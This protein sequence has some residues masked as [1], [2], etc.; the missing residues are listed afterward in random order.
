MTDK[1]VTEKRFRVNTALRLEVKYFDN[2]DQEVYENQR[3]IL[4][5]DCNDASIS[6]CGDILTP[7]QLRKLANELEAAS[8]LADSLVKK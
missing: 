6:L 7:E 4:D 3:L 1:L 5:A 2:G 8:I